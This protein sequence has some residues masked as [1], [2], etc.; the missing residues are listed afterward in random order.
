MKEKDFAEL[1]ESIRQAG[2]IQRGEMAPSRVFHYDMNEIET[3]KTK[4][5]K[6]KSQSEVLYEGSDST[7]QDRELVER[8]TK[9][10]EPL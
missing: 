2:K 4:L 6:S 8:K 7:L 1:L 5:Q 9:Q 10:P 3:I